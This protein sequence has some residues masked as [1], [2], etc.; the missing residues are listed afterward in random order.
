MFTKLQASMTRG[1]FF[2]R[3]HGYYFTNTDKRSRPIM[4]LGFFL[5][6]VVLSI[7]GHGL[8]PWAPFSVSSETSQ[9]WM[10][11][12]QVEV[13]LRLSVVGIGRAE[14]PVFNILPATCAHL[15]PRL[16]PPSFAFEKEDRCRCSGFKSLQCR[17]LRAW[18]SKSKPLHIHV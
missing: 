14:M 8:F 4:W 7:N 3:R 1:Q 12:L 9:D 11:V 6:L 15:L 10:G 16:F 5:A 2:H 13:H 17:V 18:T